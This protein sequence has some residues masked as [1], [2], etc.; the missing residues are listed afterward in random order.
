MANKAGTIVNDFQVANNQIP[1]IERVMQLIE[2]DNTPIIARYFFS[3]KT[4]KPV[5]TATGKYSWF[6]DEYL[7]FQTTVTAIT[8]GA[9]SEDNIT[10]GDATWINEGDI[11][12]IETTEEMV[13][14]DSIASSQIDI[15]KIGAGNITACTTGYLTKIG[16][17][18]A[19]VAGY[20][21]AFSTQEVEKYN[22]NTIFSE[23]VSVSDRVQ[24]GKKYTHDDEE[25]YQ[26]KKKM[27]ELKNQIERNFKYS[28]YKGVNSTSND[29]RVTLGEGFLSVV[30]TNKQSYAT[31]SSDVIYDYLADVC[32]RGSTKKVHLMGSNHYL[33]I[34]N[35]VKND[36][37]GNYQIGEKSTEYGMNVV[38]LY[39]PH[40][41]LKL[42]LDKS[43]QGKFTN[44]G[45]TLDEEHIQ[46]R[47][48][49]DDNIGSR[50]MRTEEL[51]RTQ[52]KNETK[53]LSD[54]S[55]MVKNEFTH[56]ILYRGS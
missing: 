23:T 36:S 45:L 7:P 31:L 32:K 52:S 54:C 17:Y 2:P 27:Y 25:A 28:V 50:K 10:V 38:K 55:L 12:L 41:E 53:L 35:A 51:P 42:I 19:E 4:A 24:S 26:L 18:N 37:T 21:T 56:G 39:N 9:T 47:Y 13:Y 6:E 15:T 29:S 16:S 34:M 33:D 5:Y 48:Q 20:R 30:T 14:V 49:G 46:V 8:G 40:G 22:Y 3:N 43:M 1:D 11:L 44:Y